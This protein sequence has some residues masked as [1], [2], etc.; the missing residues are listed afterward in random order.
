MMIVMRMLKIIMHG[1][2]LMCYGQRGYLE[3]N[4]DWHYL[5]FAQTACRNHQS[6]PKCE[7]ADVSASLVEI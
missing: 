6:T 1:D 4:S 5:R 3:D 7:K 2:G